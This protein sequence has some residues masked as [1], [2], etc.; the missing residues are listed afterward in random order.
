MA[1]GNAGA[2]AQPEARL[3]HLALSGA[4]PIHVVS[5]IAPSGAHALA[6]AIIGKVGN[7]VKTT[8][9]HPHIHAADPATRLGIPMTFNG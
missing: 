6:F 1:P 8:E 2:L 7:A 3:M 9:P 5:G 4:A